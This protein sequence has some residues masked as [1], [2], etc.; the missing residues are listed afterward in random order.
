MNHI[1]YNVAILA[2]VAMVGIGFALFH[3]P[4]ALVAV[5]LLIIVLTIYA[6]H[7]GANK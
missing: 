1:Y 6:V 5:G 4:S 7:L 2:G 3:V